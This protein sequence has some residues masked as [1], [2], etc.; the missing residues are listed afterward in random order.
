MEREGS[1]FPINFHQ[2]YDVW[3]LMRYG[4]VNQSKCSVLTAK[5]LYNIF[6]Q[7]NTN[8][9]ECKHWKIDVRGCHTGMLR[10]YFGPKCHSY[11]TIFGCKNLSDGFLWGRNSSLG[12]GCSILSKYENKWQDNCV[13]STIL[14]YKVYLTPLTFFQYIKSHFNA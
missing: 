3:W 5:H 1:I 2:C 13:N 12:G 4:L 9:R 14:Y 6:L 10:K 8:L 11:E 7:K